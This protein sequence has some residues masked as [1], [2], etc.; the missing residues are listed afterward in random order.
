M[1]ILGI[2]GFE[3]LA[4]GEPRH[5]RASPIRRPEDL[6]T[7]SEG[8]I[9]LQ[10]LP[11][12]L[13]GHD[14]SACL[15][16][17]GRLVAF[18]A[19]E[20][21]TRIKH[22]FNLAGETVLPR[23]AIAYCL[24]EAGIDWKDV[25]YIAHYCR[26]TKAAVAQRLGRLSK[27]L[28]LPRASLLRKEH[29]RTYSLRLSKAV[30]LKQ[31][32]QLA[33][34]RIEGN[35]LIQ[36]PHHLAHAAGAFFSSPFE[37]ASILAV[38]GYGEV[39]ST[40][41][42]EGRGHRLQG[43]GSIALPHSLGV[44][45]QIITSYLGFRS[46]GDEYKV[47]GLAAYGDPDRYR[48]VFS[49]WVKPD[50]P[51]GTFRLD[52]LSTPDL[53]VRLRSAFGEIETPGEFSTKAADIAAALQDTL[54][55]ILVHMLSH[56]RKKYRH[57]Y[58]CLSGGVALN[59]SANGALMRSE[60]FE[61][62]FIQPAASDEGGSLGAAL[63]AWHETLCQERS[64]ALDHVFWGPRSNDQ[65]IEKALQADD[66]LIWNKV[67]R[68]A[69]ATADLLAE[70]KIVGWF[71]GRMEMGPRALGGRSILAD[72]RRIEIRDRLN[73][74]IKNREMFRP[75]APSVLK[76]HAK[77][78][79]DFPGKEASPFML[80]TF[81][82][83]PER[84]AAIPGVVHFDGSSRIQ[85]VGPHQAPRFHELLRCFYKKTGIPLLLNT[86]FNRAGEPIVCSPEDAVRCFVASG[87]DA[88]AIEDRLVRRR[89]EPQKK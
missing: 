2:S 24:Q 81:A 22:G 71:Q 83:R 20:R 55:S 58:C 17:D 41:W 79:F 69:E 7:F 84:R 62:L 32:N 56:I 76:D 73:R 70:G 50:L 44:L 36:V 59:A 42:G 18:A 61:D 54:E 12:G 35:R 29:E 47:M 78:Y 30:L 64:P 14:S 77:D 28:D 86:S 60:L 1:M 48:H 16:Q 65:D 66:T 85:T 26:F 8:R 52:G 10:F 40:L 19:E 82:T 57:K 13:I 9:P 3:S 49:G 43:L 87:L 88:L 15:L 37:E 31:L 25:D 67:P 53:Y 75:F 80:I 38:D 34:G 23:Q 45:Y 68:I 63:Y 89:V 21:M 5:S 72:P 46:F 4:G 74:L 6:W 27:G 11:L 51:N 39:S 33:G